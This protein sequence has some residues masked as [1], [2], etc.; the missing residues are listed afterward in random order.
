MVEYYLHLFPDTASHDAVYDG[1][2]YREPWVALTEQ[3]S[4]VTY[5]RPPSW[6]FDEAILDLSLYDQEKLVVE[7]LGADGY[8][9]YLSNSAQTVQ[10]IMSDG[11]NFSAAVNVRGREMTIPSDASFKLI[12]Y[13]EVSLPGREFTYDDITVQTG[14][15]EDYYVYLYDLST[16]TA[17]RVHCVTGG[18]TYFEIPHNFTAV[19]L[20]EREFSSKRLREKLDVDL[21]QHLPVL[22]DNVY[23]GSYVRENYYNED[24]IFVFTNDIETEDPEYFVNVMCGVK[25]SDFFT[26]N[27]MSGDASNLFTM[28]ITRK[29]FWTDNVQVSYLD[30]QL[31]YWYDGVLPETGFDIPREVDFYVRL[32][33]D[34][35]EVARSDASKLTNYTVF[36]K[37]SKFSNTGDEF[38][39]D[40]LLSHR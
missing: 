10:S 7:D 34:G 36:Y 19:P 25:F 28:D 4:A 35:T 15:S 22:T 38:S 18:S 23:G 29:P 12:A 39:V 3:T 21:V 1:D 11:I 14:G 32:T 2:Q 37:G 24:G 16:D 13:Q 26:V 31:R 9:M 20:T 6:T 27:S 8:Y 40:V 33:I 17:T 5:N 30:N